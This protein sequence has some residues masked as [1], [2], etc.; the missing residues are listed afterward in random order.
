M[1][2]GSFI[3]AS[4]RRLRSPVQGGGGRVLAPPPPSRAQR[5]ATLV[6]PWRAP[7]PPLP[8]TRCQPPFKAAKKHLRPKCEVGGGPM[9]GLESK[10]SVRGRA[11]AASLSRQWR[12]RSPLKRLRARRPG[13]KRTTRR[14]AASL[15]ACHILLPLH[16]TFVL[17]QRR[18]F[19]SR[20]PQRREETQAFC[21]HQG[22]CCCCDEL[23]HHGLRASLCALDTSSGLVHRPK[24]L[25]RPQLRF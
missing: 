13:Q 12:R 7:P 24:D 16:Q 9:K 10:V 25:Y 1:R 3:P 21:T 2:S 11:A 17:V 4:R 20:P 6:T 14:P 19:T 8:Q 5:Q 15:I 18:F 22:C 23:D